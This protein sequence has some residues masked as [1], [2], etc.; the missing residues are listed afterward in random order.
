MF[1]IVECHTVEGGWSGDLAAGALGALLKLLSYAR[2]FYWNRGGVPLRDLTAGWRARRGIREPDWHAMLK[3]AQKAGEIALRNG[4]LEILNPDWLRSPTSRLDRTKAERMRRLRARKGGGGVARRGAPPPG[5]GA[6]A[7]ARHG[8][9]RGATGGRGAPHIEEEDQLQPD[10]EE[11]EQEEKKSRTKQPQ[12]QPK[13]EA[14]AGDTAGPP[15]TAG[16]ASS[17]TPP[18]RIAREDL[19]WDRILELSLQNLAF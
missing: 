2:I 15:D 17:G 8:A 1:I 14:P 11:E 13:E 7:V 4:W 12:P 3:T 10:V 6:G 9:P 18:R 5:D 16:G 19:T